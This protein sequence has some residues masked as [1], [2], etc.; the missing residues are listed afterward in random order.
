MR[1]TDIKENDKII[2]MPV[3]LTG[4]TGKTRIKH[5]NNIY[6]YG[7]PF[8]SRRIEF[9]EN[10]YVKWQIGYDVKTSDVGPKK[11]TTLTDKSFT[12]ANGAEKYLYELSEYISYFYKWDIIS[13]ETLLGIKDYLSDLSKEDFI[14]QNEEFEITR[15]NIVKKSVLDLSYTTATVQYPLL[16][17]E[18]EGSDAYIEIV[19]KEKQYAIGT[20]P[21][22]Y[23]CFPVTMLSADSPL[24]GRIA[25]KKEEA[26]LIINEDNIFIFTELLKIFGTLSESHNKDI[27]NILN[28]IL[29]F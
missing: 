6:E 17:H 4:G 19:I 18:F 20:Q 13:K 15:T 9:N 21:M 5:R 3:P 10:C 7:V 11:E 8:S 26:T 27:I 23:F 12:G 1:I 25:E 14:D 16:I 2:E 22:L 24:I 28:L 29:N